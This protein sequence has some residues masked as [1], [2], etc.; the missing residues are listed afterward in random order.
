MGQHLTAYHIKDNFAALVTDS[1]EILLNR[2]KSVTAYNPVEGIEFEARL[3]VE[4]TTPKQVPWQ[5]FLNQGFNDLPALNTKTENSVLF[6]KVPY[7]EKTEIFA[8]TFGMG[9]FLLNS[10]CY[11]KSYGLHVALNVIYEKTT[12]PNRIKSVST[13]AIEPNPLRTTRQRDRNSAFEM[14][15]VDTISD[16]LTGITGIPVRADYWSSLMT[17]ADSITAK[18]S[19]TFQKLGEYCIDILKNRETDK[20]KK[21]FSWIDDGEM[22]TDTDLSEELNRCVI[23][24]IKNRPG[25]LILTFPEEVDWENMDTCNILYE[26]KTVAFDP[27]TDEVNQ[28]LNKMGLLDKIDIDMLQQDLYMVASDTDGKSYLYSFWNCLSGEIDQSIES[29]CQYIMSEGEFHKYGSGYIDKLNTYLNNLPEF[30][31]DFLPC[32]LTQVDNKLKAEEEGEYSKRVAKE[33]E[34]L[35]VLDRKNVIIPEKTTAIEICDLLSDERHLIHV[36]PKLHSS[37]LSHL[38]WQ[39]YVSADMLQTNGEFREKALDII[40]REVKIKAPSAG[41]SYINKFCTFTPAQITPADYTVTYAIIAD[42]PENK[43]FAETL[44]FFSRVSLRTQ[45]LNIRR[46]G[47]KVSRACIKYQQE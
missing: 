30:T 40:K 22:V 4:N 9:R 36:K 27:N 26:D 16:N 47:Y 12:S 3:F 25:Y 42:W 46:R 37:T 14:F 2:T 44:P 1:Y 15:E 10:K 8:F 18:P 17:G 7:K 32:R 21:S 24:T 33:D 19:I 41:A 34:H 6:I 38:F 11:E 28:V 45:V 43:T 35:L 23:P 13:K 39:G 5:V 29:R 31:Y 20:Y